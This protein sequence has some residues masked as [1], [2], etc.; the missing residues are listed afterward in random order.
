MT[1]TVRA[2]LTIQRIGDEDTSIPAHKRNGQAD[3]MRRRA[4]LDGH[5]AKPVEVSR[6]D[7]EAALVATAVVR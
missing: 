2:V 6:E 4:G 1:V 7:L 5:G 3:P